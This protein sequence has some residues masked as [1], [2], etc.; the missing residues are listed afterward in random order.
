MAGLLMLW[1]IIEELFPLLQVVYVVFLRNN[2]PAVWWV[3]WLVVRGSLVEM[4][5][6]Q[7]LA[8]WFK[9]L[10]RHRWHLY[11][12]LGKKIIWRVFDH[13]HLAITLIGFLKW[14]WPPIFLQREFPFSKPGLLGRLQSSQHSEY[15]GYSR[16]ADESFRNG[17]EDGNQK[18]RET[19][20]KIGVPLS[21]L[22]EW[23][24]GYR[25]PRTIK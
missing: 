9:S 17:R 7:A 11:T 18:F 25:K 1:L 6:V 10:G 5:F 14:Y 15:E 22:W 19:Y 16:A 2:S 24:L 8:L 3:K 13:A 12:F 4:Q 23:S 21:E 20:W